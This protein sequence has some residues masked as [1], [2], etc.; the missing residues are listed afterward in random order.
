VYG[1]RPGAE[2]YR[3]S[4]TQVDNH[5]PFAIELF[6]LTELFGEIIFPYSF[7]PA[8]YTDI[9]FDADFNVGI[10]GYSIPLR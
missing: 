6:Q 10:F 1:S 9:H 5:F 2:A 3:A 8:G 4:N 7:E